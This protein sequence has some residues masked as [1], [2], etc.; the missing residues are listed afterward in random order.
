MSKAAK[1]LS[2]G[3][4]MPIVD[5]ALDA[6]F[7]VFRDTDTAL[8]EIIGAHGDEIRAI[9]T[10]G[11]SPTNEALMARLPKL[12][13]IANFGVG[14]DSID[15]A[16]AARRGIV[17]TN[18]PDVLN[19][20]M[21]DFTVGLLLATVRALPQAERHLRA[22]HWLDRP[23]PLGNTL[24][25]R[26][27][28]IAGMGRIG[29]VIARRLSGF[30]VPISYHARNR[31][32]DVAYPHYPDL[33]A[34]AAA[35][36]VLIVVLPGGAATRNIVDAEIL[37]ALGPDGILINVARGSVVDEPA[38]IQALRDKTILAAGIDVFAAEP[39]VPAELIAMDH[40]VLVP[41]VGTATHHTRG[42]MA[43][44]VIEN[45]ISWFSG[46]GAVTPVS[47]TPQRR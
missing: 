20:E 5:E 22:G 30:D 15:A 26:S 18:T 41:H 46:H 17:V 38:L 11:R 45:I 1:I 14:Y 8:D 37:K 13:L 10:R 2:L 39:H 6:R 40:V 25:G 27:I 32:P 4:I 29:R 35:V 31:V 23:F 3:A 34:L 42:L 7:E 47:E 24:R 9:V 33:K 36:D 28:G 43:N 16:A 44:L 21:G 19:D 12:E